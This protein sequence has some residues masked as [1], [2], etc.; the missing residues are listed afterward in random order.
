[1]SFPVINTQL[2]NGCQACV[3]IC[4]DGVYEM[5]DGKAVVIAAEDCSGCEACIPVCLVD[6]IVMQDD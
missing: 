5:R 3:D 1:M 4:P 6:C 2:C